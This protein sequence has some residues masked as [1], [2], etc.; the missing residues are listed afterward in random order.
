LTEHFKQVDVGIAQT[1]RLD[2]IAKK[3]DET[4]QGLR[5]KLSPVSFRLFRLSGMIEAAFRLRCFQLCQ[6][7][8]VKIFLILNGL[9]K[10]GEIIG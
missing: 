1:S 3:E 6:I 10:L 7:D 4:F 9:E 8:D 5:I 2:P